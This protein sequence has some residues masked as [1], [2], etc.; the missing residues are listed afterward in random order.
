M[1]TQ[2]TYTPTLII[3]LFIFSMTLACNGEKASER[4]QSNALIAEE[5]NQEADAEKEAMDPCQLTDNSTEAD[6]AEIDAALDDETISDMDET[7]PS[8]GNGN[9][10]GNGNTKKKNETEESEDETADQAEEPSSESPKDTKDAECPSDPLQDEPE[11]AEPNPEDGATQ[12]IPSFAADIEPLLTRS[13]NN[14]HSTQSPAGDIPTDSYEAA[15]AHFDSILDSIANARMP[16][17]N[18]PEF[19]EDEIARLKAWA[20]GD[21]AP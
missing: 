4:G 8:K 10:N 18:A 16:L 2:K 13:C 20:E 14:C 11:S 5:N 3:T 15:I 21:F 19:S 9:G 12:L 6:I 1:K 17:G 7:E